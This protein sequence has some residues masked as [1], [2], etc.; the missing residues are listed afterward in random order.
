MSITILKGS[1]ETIALLL[2]LKHDE[3]ITSSKIREKFKSTSS[4]T[5]YMRL[6]KLINQGLLLKKTKKG[7]F[8]GD[9]RTE[10]T[11]SEKGL[12]ARKN[13]IDYNITIL[14]PIINL[15]IKE[16]TLGMENT[17]VED[18]NEKVQ[19][20]LIEFSEEIS[21]IVNNKS[22]INLQKIIEKLLKKYL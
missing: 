20:F 3:Y 11:L 22:I 21:D 9:D 5:L 4:G 10:Y 8:A 1:L 6:K 2:F 15:L 17:E 14:N 16:K 18:K 7:A 19:D 13:L 12:K